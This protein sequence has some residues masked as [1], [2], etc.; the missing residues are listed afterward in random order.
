[1]KYSMCSVTLLN[2][3]VKDAFELMK[4]AGYR[5]ADVHARH[6]PVTFTP[7]E[8]EAV[9]ALAHSYGL[10]IV[11]LASI[12]GGGLGDADAGKRRAAAQEI[13]RCIDQ[14]AQV[15]AGVIRIGL[16]NL[17]PGDER[18]KR[19]VVP[20]LRETIEYAEKKNVR[21][22][23]ENHSGGTAQSVAGS[24]EIC[25]AIPS[26]WFGLI[27]DP[28]NLLGQ[29]QDYKKVLEL[30]PDRIVHVHL[31]DGFPKNFG[32]PDPVY[33]QR[34]SCTAFGKGRLDIPFIMR[35]LK[36]IGY[37]GYVSVEYEAWHPE[38]NLPPVLPGLKD[39]LDYLNNL[40][41]DE[42]G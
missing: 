12:V 13:V 28:G 8:V 27:Y 4:A 29:H 16:G 10:S 36:R 32:D 24:L 5:Y 42:V 34:L 3:P 33:A 31:K 20:A 30:L 38:Y 25:E 37:G 2:S 9:N 19:L 35:E 22:G 1:M 21:M 15:G 7:A 26:P 39:C 23:V 40:R 18:L 41:S 17:L 14:A 11:S 6:L